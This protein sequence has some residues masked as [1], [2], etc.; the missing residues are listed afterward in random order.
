MDITMQF[1]GELGGVGV[2]R[3]ETRQERERYWS[4]SER[5]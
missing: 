2:D 3:Q 5:S 4:G 1:I